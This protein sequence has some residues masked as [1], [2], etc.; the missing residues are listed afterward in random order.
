MATDEGITP[1]EW[2]GDGFGAVRVDAFGHLLLAS[3][4]GQAIYVCVALWLIPDRCIEKVL[5]AK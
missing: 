5:P 4:I 3:W 1:S 2:M